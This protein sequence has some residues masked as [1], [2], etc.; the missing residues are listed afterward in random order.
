V[1]CSTMVVTGYDEE[2]TRGDVVSTLLS[3]QGGLGIDI[4]YTGW[5]PGLPN[6]LEGKF[7]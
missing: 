7:N 6:F 2:E 4:C 3:T 1:G 5:V